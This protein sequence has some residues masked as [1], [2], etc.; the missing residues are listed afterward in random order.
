MLAVKDLETENPIVGEI[1]SR[2]F[3]LLI[4]NIQIRMLKGMTFIFGGNQIMICLK[5]FKKR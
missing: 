1:N 4:G 3:R 2:N 5:K